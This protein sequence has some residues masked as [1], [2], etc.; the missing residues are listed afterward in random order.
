MRNTRRCGASR[1]PVR[2]VVMVVMM[3]VHCGFGVAT[4]AGAPDV[5]TQGGVVSAVANVTTHQFTVRV[6]DEVRDMP[7]SM[8]K[9]GY[10]TPL[11]T[12]EVLE[13]SRYLTMDSSTYGVPVDSPEGYRIDTEFAV[14]L[15]WGGIFVH[16][17]PW[18]VESQGYANVSHGC[19]NLSPENA[20][21]FY[22]NVQVGDTVTIVA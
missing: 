2:V 19:I 1:Y 22:E 16:S 6:G 18:S 21:W 5:R 9:P 4:A 17:A 11:G 13:K 8:G 20:Q 7:A 3:L 10:E 14:R 15:T 12:F